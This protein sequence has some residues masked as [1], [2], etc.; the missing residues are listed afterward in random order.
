M[1][2]LL[3]A[4]VM[5]LVATFSQAVAQMPAKP[6]IKMGLWDLDRTSKTTRPD[7]NE[8]TTSHKFQTC[9][10]ESNW[11]TLVGPTAP[12]CTKTNEVWST[13][14]YDFDVACPTNPKTASIAI[15][16]DNP[17]T[18]HVILHVYATHEGTPVNIAQEVEGRWISATCG[19][20]S[21]DRPAPVH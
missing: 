11:S 2:M 8:G 12:G 15:H 10:T 19:D 5:L 6:P 17:E 16:F 20:V 21:T 18:Q 4:L 3:I 7:G 1:K 9:V 13:K 14:S